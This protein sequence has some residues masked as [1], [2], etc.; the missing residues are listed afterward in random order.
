MALDLDFLNTLRGQYGGLGGDLGQVT[1]FSDI[2]FGQLPGQ[3]AGAD[4]TVQMRQLMLQTLQAEEQARTTRFQAVAAARQGDWALYNQM[5][6]LANTYDTQ[7]RQLNQQAEQFGA[8]MGLSRDQLAFQMEQGRRQLGL[9]E[10]QQGFQEDVELARL[11]ANPE[12][13]IQSA[14]LQGS[15]RPGGAL[16]TDGAIGTQ[17]YRPQDAGGGLNAQSDQR[18]AQY[19]RQVQD[20]PVSYQ[21]ALGQQQ[22]P[23]AG[24]VEALRTRSRV[25][26]FGAAPTQ[27][28]TTSLANLRSNPNLRLTPGGTDLASARNVIA[29]PTE[30]GILSSTL[31]AQGQRPED[32]LG[33]LRRS[34]PDQG[35]VSVS[36]VA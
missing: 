9:A 33:A 14:L 31:R 17:P 6:Q 8:Q 12:N 32:F 35:S 30:R 28:Y 2:T 5:Q 21:P 27:G 25:P 11:G 29:N 4:P 15:R 19:Q 16:P 18:N 36:R 13:L 22:V 26:Q 34:G 23:V 7:L 10:R 20:E 1:N 24:V 3:P